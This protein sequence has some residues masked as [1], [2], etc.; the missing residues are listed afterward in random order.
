[1]SDPQTTTAE[2]WKIPQLQDE[3]G[4]L[5][6]ILERKVCGDPR[7]AVSFEDIYEAE[8][9]MKILRANEARDAGT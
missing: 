7:V 9:L 6:S 4:R 3:I 1:M 2:D 5:H 8:P